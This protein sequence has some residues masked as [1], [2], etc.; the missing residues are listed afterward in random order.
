[1]KT[2][3]FFV[4]ILFAG[5]LCAAANESGLIIN[6]PATP[7]AKPPP[8]VEAAQALSTITGVAISPLAGMGAV[9]AWK[10][11]KAAPERRT[12]LAWYAQPY[13]WLPALIVVVLVGLKDILGTA[14]P[15]GLKKPF[16]VAEV[17]ENKLSGLVAAGAF[18]PLVASIFSRHDDAA[19]FGGSALA[20][21]GLHNAGLAMIDLP[22]VGNVLLMPFA[23]ASF[24]LVWLV[25]HTIHILILISPFGAVDAALKAFRTFLVGAL[26]VTS[27]TNPYLGAVMSLVII[28]LAYFLAGWSFRWMVFGSV[29][30]WDFFT[31]SRH[32]F[33]PTTNNAWM[34]SALKFDQTPVRTYGKLSR[35]EAGQL[36]FQYRPWLVAPRRSVA[37]PAVEPSVGRGLLHS[38]IVSAERADA[39]QRTLFLLPPRYRNHEAE[40]A[41]LFA[42]EGVC[43]IGLRKGF[44]A[45]WRWCAGIFGVRPKAHSLSAGT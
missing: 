4:S 16:D 39:P 35:D 9:G 15:P 18:V 23:I 32:R 41:S 43:D 3:A 6:R 1:M 42:L 17:I 14:A 25:S 5:L 24:G 28:A 34:F 36:R 31:G 7:A 37:L 33:A 44:K 21:F 27:F 30:T 40:L 20:A 2:T 26:T 13:F 38:E 45:I 19:N 10:Y 8:G 11:F 29:F 22:A 12:R